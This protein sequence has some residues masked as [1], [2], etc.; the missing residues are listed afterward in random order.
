MVFSPIFECEDYNKASIR[1]AIGMRGVLADFRNDYPENDVRFG[2]G[3]H[4]GRL[5]AG[6][7]ETDAPSEFTVIG[8]TVDL[9]ARL[10]SLTKEYGTDLLFS[11]DV[12][13][14]ISPK[15]GIFSNDLDEVQV[16]GRQKGLQI[17]TSENNF[18]KP[19]RTKTIKFK[20][21][22]SEFLTFYQKLVTKL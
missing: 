22:S 19:D 3:I 1:V 6:N 12:A 10:E 7:I 17:F 20:D 5:V 16:R 4:S 9:A 2:I 8:D 11:G 13:A 15:S 21:F 18:K 14:G